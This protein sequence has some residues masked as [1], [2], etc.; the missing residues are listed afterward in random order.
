MDELYAK[1]EQAIQ[2]EDA[3]AFERIIQER[4]VLIDDM[5]SKNQTEDLK[6]FLKRDKELVALIKRKQQTIT[7]F[8][9]QQNQKLKA[10]DKYDR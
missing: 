4:K 1:L 10:M 5:V 6:T 3:V 8:L 7:E 9:H 2:D